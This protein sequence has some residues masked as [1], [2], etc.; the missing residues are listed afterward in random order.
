MLLGGFVRVSNRDENNFELAELSQGLQD[1]RS[2]CTPDSMHTSPSHDRPY[3]PLD[4]EMSDSD[5]PNEYML[6]V[7]GRDS[8]RDWVAEEFRT[9]FDSGCPHN[10]IFR[11][12]RTKIGEVAVRPL[13][14]GRD[15]KLKGYKSPINPDDLIVPKYFIR[16]MIENAR[17]GVNDSVDLKILELPEGTSTGGVDII[18]GRNFLKKHDDPRLLEKVAVA[19]SEDP[20][21]AVATDNSICVLLKSKT[22]KSKYQ[23]IQSQKPNVANTVDAEQKLINRHEDDRRR[24]QEH[25]T[26]IE[27]YKK[28]KEP[29]SGSPMGAQ[30]TGP[31]M[32]SET[33]GCSQDI[34]AAFQHSASVQ[35]PNSFPP[36][37]YF[38]GLTAR[39]IAQERS[40]PL[41]DYLDEFRSQRSNTSSTQF[42]ENSQ[43]SL[44]RQSTSSSLESWTSIPPDG[45]KLAGHT[46]DYVVPQ[47]DSVLQKQREASS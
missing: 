3:A 19:N 34:S 22:S 41:S 40:T 16:I 4:A 33:S 2:V 23:Y 28:F 8:G 35:R 11:S 29:S 15:G 37:P 6:M 39:Q 14:P 9:L 13:P 36:S 18:L 38:G 45:G 32:W 27:L 43:L 21:L 44:D 1:S 30:S 42:T 5:A 10:F 26:A 25:A 20:R 7:R 12:G 46:M 24:K 47:A 31:A 17:I